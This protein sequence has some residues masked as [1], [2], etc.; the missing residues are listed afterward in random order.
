MAAFKTNVIPDQVDIDLDIRT[1]PD[2]EPTEPGEFLD[3]ALGEL[4]SSVELTVLREDPGSISPLGGRLWSAVTDAVAQLR[5]DAAC[6]PTLTTGGT[7]ARFYRQRGIPAYGFGLFSDRISV[8]EFGAM[9][10]GPDERID[11]ESLALSVDLW[12]AV[13]R[14]VG[15]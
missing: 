10:H 2:A 15:V 5:P 13:A 4:R 14:R 12:E 6:I 3:S 7:D 11:Q 9:F 1:L 8:E